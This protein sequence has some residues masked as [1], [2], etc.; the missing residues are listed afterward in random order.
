MKRIYFWM[1]AFF[2][3]FST[4]TVYSQA[5]ETL[6]LPETGE[7]TLIHSGWMARRAGEVLMDGNRLTSV[8]FYSS[9]WINARI[10]GTVLTTLLENK[11]FPAPEF[12][13]N[14][15]L[16]PDIYDVGNDFYTFW[17]V[18]PFR[19]ETPHDEGRNVWLNFRGINYKADIFLNGKR[20]NSNTHEGMFLRASFN[21]T[22]HLK[23]DGDNLL[24]VI[25]YPPD[26]P[27]NPNG[28]Q[29]GDAMIAR[30]VTM[31]FTPGW[32]WIQPV[33]DRNTGIWD[34]VSL[35]VTRAVRV[36]HPYVITRVPGVRF[37]EGERKD[38]YLSATVELENTSAVSRTGVL[39][40]ETNGV[41]QTM[42]VVLSPLERKLVRLNEQTVRNPR[43]WWPNGIGEQAL[44]DMRI[45]FETDGKTSDR[46]RLRYGIREIS[47][48]KDPATG[49]RKFYVNGQPVYITGGNYIASDWL[50]RLSPERYRAEIRYHAEMNL[51]MIRV[52]GGALLER[53]EFYDAC[54][55]YGLLVF[56]DL[57][58]SGDC[59]GAWDDVTKLESRERR[60]EYPD[61]H[62]LFLASVEDQVKMIRNHPS[63]CLWCGA[64]EWPLARD[65]DE[66]LKNDVFPRLDPHRLYVSYSTDT[67]FTRNTIGGVGDGPYGIQEP[68]W[69]FTFR[70]TPFNPEAGSVGSPEVESMRLMMTEDELAV[71]PRGRRVHPT[72]QYHRDL[73]Y[74][75]HLERYGKVTNI[76]SYCKYAQTVNYDQYRSFMEGRASRMWEW[77][78]GILIWKTQNPW[79]SLRGQMYDW[80]LD[81]NASLY[82]TRKGCEP[83]HPQYNLDSRQVEIVNIT[84]RSH[85]LSLTARL[86]RPD[87]S[88]CWEQTE[89]VAIGSNSVKRLFSV[90]SPEGVEG[91][92][93]L[94]L[95]MYENGKEITDNIYWLTTRPKDYS[96]LDSL[97][98]VTPNVTVT[99]RADGAGHT[100]KVRLRATGG[101]S[102]FNRIKV[103]DKATGERVLPVHYSDN[104]VT[105]M[106]GDEREI[107]VHIP[108]G[109]PKE[110]LQIVIDSWTADRIVVK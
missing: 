86:Y 27:G 90:P 75:D 13:M 63:L 32:D 46:Q 7:K 4:E 39:V 60:W 35:T 22:P 85:S 93:F 87:G 49:G 33:H 66:A 34:E 71:L 108:V 95:I 20:L 106:P 15:K 11:F 44:Y 89:S 72:W 104:Y 3:V 82:G 59:N 8:P 38:A 48:E 77:Y 109:I 37:P 52:W 45:A 78:T 91:V 74:G 88:V 80:F 70:S 56:Q 36:R 6:R 110:R 67:V 28:G 12:S 2:L 83:L 92:Y 14:N 76:E 9:G 107:T 5:V 57:W 94:K 101:I 29:G 99:V 79:T 58:G 68:E 23:P 81:V 96:G 26:H 103:F 84:P 19:L 21:I 65:I 97:P 55:E 30:N 43:L 16:I 47:S 102:F 64:N 18:R 73:G 61:N 40:C 69:F 17:F 31:Q 41:R 100:A 105:L 98:R 53:P 24:A 62:G 50:L 25:V 51:R 10:P 42:S 1:T 54:D